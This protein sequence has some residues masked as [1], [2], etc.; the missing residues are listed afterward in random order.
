MGFGVGFG[1]A[2][3]EGFAEVGKVLLDALEPEV[4]DDVEGEDE[5][6]DSDIESE[7]EDEEMT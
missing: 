5:E 6:D 1:A 4:G 3:E 2:A 7:D